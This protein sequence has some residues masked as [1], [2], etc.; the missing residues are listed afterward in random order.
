MPRL[1]PSGWEWV[2]GGSAGLHIVGKGKRMIII[3]E[4]INTSRKAINAAI[5]RKDKAFF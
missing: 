2:S 1:L 5:D 4:R 3:G